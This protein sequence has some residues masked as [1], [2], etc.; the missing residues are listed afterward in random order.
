MVA[1]RLFPAGLIYFLKVFHFRFP[2]SSS[3]YQPPLWLAMPVGWLR[4]FGIENGELLHWLPQLLSERTNVKKFFYPSLLID[5]W[6]RWLG[7]E[8]ATYMGL[9]GSVG[10]WLVGILVLNPQRH[11]HALEPTN[12]HGSSCTASSP[13]KMAAGWMSMIRSPSGWQLY[14]TGLTAMVSW[15]MSLEFGL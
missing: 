9:V 12:L 2:S 15:F 11:S 14:Q 8:P 7:A 4:W 10:G 5:S 6:W 1:I 13:K 3:S